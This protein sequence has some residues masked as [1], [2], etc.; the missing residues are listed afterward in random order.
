MVELY[1]P[2]ANSFPTSKI[3]E[4]ALK[5]AGTKE[6][7]AYASSPASPI[8]GRPMQRYSIRMQG[9]AIPVWADL[10]YNVVFPAFKQ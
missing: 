6:V 10:N 7:R 1:D 9:R 5:E 4:K 2:L 8:T 3:K